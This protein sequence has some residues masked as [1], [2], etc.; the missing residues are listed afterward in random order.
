[1]NH[2]S[3]Y[4]QIACVPTDARRREPRNETG[5]REWEIDVRNAA[6]FQF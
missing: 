1:M 2:R 5:M 6:G 4:G 3:D